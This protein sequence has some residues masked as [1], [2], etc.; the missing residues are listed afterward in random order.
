MEYFD[1]DSEDVNINHLTECPLAFEYH[2]ALH[3]PGGDFLVLKI[4]ILIHKIK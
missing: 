1:I 3:G 4:F 2:D